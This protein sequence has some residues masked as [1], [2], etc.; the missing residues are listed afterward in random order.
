MT[1]WK[2]VRT[3]DLSNSKLQKENYH[4]QDLFYHILAIIQLT[5]IP[6]IPEE[7]FYNTRRNVNLHPQFCIGFVRFNRLI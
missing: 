4:P 5:K 6:L 1:T 2:Y 7:I 3:V